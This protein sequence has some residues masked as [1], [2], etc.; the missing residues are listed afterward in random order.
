[1]YPRVPLKLLLDDVCQAAGGT[2]PNWVK[3]PAVVGRGRA[4]GR[5]RLIRTDGR[6]S[7]EAVIRGLSHQSRERLTL[8]GGENRIDRGSGLLVEFGQRFRKFRQ[9]NL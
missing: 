4:Y 9:R 8:L 1:M 5:R 2:V 7:R 6:V 3:Q